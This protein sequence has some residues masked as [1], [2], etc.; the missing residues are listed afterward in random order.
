MGIFS[1]FK[2]PAKKEEKAAKREPKVKVAK[3]EEVKMEPEIKEQKIKEEKAAIKPTKTNKELK[4]KI[5]SKKEFHGVLI[6]PLITEKSTGLGILNKYVFA[7]DIG[8]NKIQI[9]QAILNRYGVKPASVN[10]LNFSGKKVRMGRSF[11]TRKGW[12]KAI[13]TLPEGQAIQIQEGT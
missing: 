6:R 1:S 3:K 10:I 4:E 5:L 2:K 7:V 11:G 12:K 9:A 8:A 13:I